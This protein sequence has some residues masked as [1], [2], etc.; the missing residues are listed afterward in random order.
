MKKLWWVSTR[1]KLDADENIFYESTY[2]CTEVKSRSSAHIIGALPTAQ[3]FYSVHQIQ[4]AA[5]HFALSLIHFYSTLLKQAFV[6]VPS[7]NLRCAVGMWP[8]HFM[9]VCNYHDPPTSTHPLTC[10]KISFEIGR[11]KCMRK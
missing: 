5:S 10:I 4:L 3:S 8:C 6:S 9:N 7:A 1:I 11:I 2:F